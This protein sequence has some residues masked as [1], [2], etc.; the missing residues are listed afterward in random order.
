MVRE[1]M[2]QILPTTGESG[3]VRNGRT[4]RNSRSSVV[5]CSSPG[6]GDAQNSPSDNPDNVGVDPERQ[7]KTGDATAAQPRY[8]RNPQLTLQDTIQMRRE[9]SDLLS[10]LLA[11]RERI[12]ARIAETGRRDPLKSVTGRTAMD[13][14]IASA[15]EMIRRMDELLRQ[16]EQEIE[17]LEAPSRNGNG[18][19]GWGEA[20]PGHPEHLTGVAVPAPIVTP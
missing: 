18:V 12:E 2:V 16:M 1:A 5:G 9:A 7:L 19:H 17:L 14:A 6:C 8:V 3:Y 11:D 13:N 10:R 15:R 4:L 20:S